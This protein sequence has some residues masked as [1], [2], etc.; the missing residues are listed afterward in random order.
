MKIKVL[1]CSSAL[2]NFTIIGGQLYFNTKGGMF[3]AEFK[4]IAEASR[5]TDEPEHRIRN[6]AQGKGNKE[7]MFIWR[8]K[9]PEKTEEYSRKFSHV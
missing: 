6:I 7:A 4:S 1:E 9:N 8:F 2:K 3:I 5:K